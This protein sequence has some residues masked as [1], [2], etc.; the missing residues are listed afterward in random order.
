VD[1]VRSSITRSP[2][3]RAG[4]VPQR[5]EIEQSLVDRGSANGTMLH[6]KPLGGDPVR[7]RSGD[8]IAFGCIKAEFVDAGR[9]WDLLTGF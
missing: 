2:A 7:V 9:L 5:I 6:G 1:T 3:R 8:A 4:V